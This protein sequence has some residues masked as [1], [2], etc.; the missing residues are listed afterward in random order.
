MT[1]VS[2]ITNMLQ[3]QNILLG[4]ML[5]QFK[6]IN[7]PLVI[8]T[9]AG[10]PALAPLGVLAYAS[11]GRN[12]GQGAGAGTGTAV[13]GNGTVWTAIWSGAQVLA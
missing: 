1:D 9:V 2:Q 12:N 4:E 13:V 6:A 8:Y 7:T 10:L 5:Q 3:A 11:N